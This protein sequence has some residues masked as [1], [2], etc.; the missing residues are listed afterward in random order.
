M[1]GR[2]ASAGC[3]QVPIMRPFDARPAQAPARPTI[4]PSFAPSGPLPWAVSSATR[5]RAMC[6]SSRRSCCPGC[7]TAPGCLPGRTARSSRS[8][9]AMPNPA[10]PR[11]CEGIL[12]RRRRLD[13]PRLHLRRPRHPRQPIDF[14]PGGG[15]EGSPPRSGRSPLETRIT[16]L[17][18][19]PES[20]A[21]GWTTYGRPPV[22]R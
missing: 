17:L 6:W 10:L 12:H 4:W 16:R 20:K 3:I 19:S 18:I 1:H 21:N 2:I 11:P 22:L 5:A 8:P 7:T 15:D 14:R 9:T 13:R